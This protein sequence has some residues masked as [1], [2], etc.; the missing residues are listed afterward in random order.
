M[1][2]KGQEV[3][4]IDIIDLKKIREYL[5]EKGNIN[6]LAFINIGINTALKISELSKM[7]FEDL[8]F[9]WSIDI[10]DSKDRKKQTI[11]F[12]RLCIDSIKKLKDFYKEKGYSV[13][14]GY[15]FKSLSSHNILHHIDSPITTNGVSR[16]F[17]KLREVLNISYPIGTQSLR[18][19][20]G[21]YVYRETKD[22]Y[23]VMK[24]LNKYTIE[25]TLKYIGYEEETTINLDK[26]EI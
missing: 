2:K 5:E 17:V 1:N 15:I 12:N 4:K 13:E 11:K 24:V 9:D 16:Q 3:S 19:T 7:R 26:F 8:K 21:Y 14:E 6:L 23:L 18:K 22:I 20:W 25:E 10:F